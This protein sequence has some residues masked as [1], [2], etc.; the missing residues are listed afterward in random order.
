MLLTSIPKHWSPKVPNDKS[1]SWYTPDGSS[2]NSLISL[3]LC[4]K[5]IT[6]EVGVMDYVKLL[7]RKRNC[8]HM[9]TQLPTWNALFDLPPEQWL[10]TQNAWLCYSPFEKGTASLDSR[11]YQLRSLEF[12]CLSVLSALLSSK[13][14]SLDFTTSLYLTEIILFS[15]CALTSVQT[16]TARFIHPPVP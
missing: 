8:Q 16:P 3:V 11:G 2:F 7:K 4:S 12:Y 1:L 9:L 15:G 6:K 13:N 5:W 14:F 10:M